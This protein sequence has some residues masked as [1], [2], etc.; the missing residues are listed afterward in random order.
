[1]MIFII[2]HIHTGVTIVEEGSLRPKLVR[3]QTT[4][5]YAMPQMEDKLPKKVMIEKKFSQ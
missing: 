3:L 2:S 1:M 4:F 5:S